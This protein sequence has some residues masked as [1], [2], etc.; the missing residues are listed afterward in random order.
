MKFEN[1]HTYPNLYVAFLKVSTLETV[2]KRI[3][4]TVCVIDG[5]M[6]TEGVSTTKWLREQMNAHTNANTCGRGVLWGYHIEWTELGNVYLYLCSAN[7][8]LCVL[9]I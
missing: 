2:L 4:A 1:V 3:A 7:L 8:V 5:Y 6:W 9:M